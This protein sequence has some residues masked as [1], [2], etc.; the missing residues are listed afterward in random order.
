MNN[1]EGFCI[2]KVLS[3]GRIAQPKHF[4]DFSSYSASA[5]SLIEQR[6]GAIHEEDYEHKDFGVIFAS[7]IGHFFKSIV[8]VRYF[9]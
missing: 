8:N 6:D 4:A 2:D 1:H 9:S 3:D 5:Y 7:R